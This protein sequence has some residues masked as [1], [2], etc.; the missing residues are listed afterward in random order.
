MYN[1]LNLTQIFFCFF[2]LLIPSFI[3][4]KKGRPDKFNLIILYLFIFVCL[5]ITI[6]TRDFKHLPDQN[7]YINFFQI[8]IKSGSN[9]LSYVASLEPSFKLISSIVKY[10]FFSEVFMLFFIYTIIGFII[11]NIYIYKL[12]TENKYIFLSLLIYCSYFLIL[13]DFIQIRVGAAISF[14][15]IAIKYK[16]EKKYVKEIIFLILSVFFHYSAVFGF[17]II[18]LPYKT[19][20]KTKLYIL[21]LFI[22]L[23]IAILHINIISIFTFLPDVYLQKIKMYMNYKTDDFSIFSLSKLVRYFFIFIILM[24]S[25]KIKNPYMLI[26]CKLYY[27]S[28]FFQLIFSTIPVLP[29]RISEFFRVSEIFV[30]PCLVSF[31]K[32]KN[33]IISILVIYC[34]YIFSFSITKYIL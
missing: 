31:F 19:E 34:I 27:F 4:I 10:F 20:W 6:I 5:F 24:N 3:P 30:L 7:E 8:Y 21:F 18:F 1:L 29:T 9:A 12:Q 16:V 23:I 2:S 15:W 22:A 28:I 32:E 17:I 26:F 33:V 14:F 11:K 25:K 13:H